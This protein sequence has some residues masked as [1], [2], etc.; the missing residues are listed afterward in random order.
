MSQAYRDTYRDPKAASTITIDAASGS[1]APDTHRRGTVP[2]PAEAGTPL[3]SG[4]RLMRI[5]I[6]PWTDGDDHLMEER[7]VVVKLT[8]GQWRLDHFKASLSKAYGPK[9][10]ASASSPAPA[11]SV[12]RT[13]PE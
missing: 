4:P 9:G 1:I 10:A 6:A 3:L 5:L 11:S 2:P 13:R 7:R 8:D 12:P